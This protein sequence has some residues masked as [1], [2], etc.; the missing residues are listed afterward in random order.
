MFFSCVY[1]GTRIVAFYDERPLAAPTIRHS[2]CSILVPQY[3][4]RCPQCTDY[5]R[6]LHA[7]VSHLSAVEGEDRIAVSSHTNYR[8][9]STPKKNKRLKLLHATSRACHAKLERLKSKLAK[10]ID[11]KGVAVEPSMTTDLHQIMREE[12]ENAL[13]EPGSFQYVFWKQQKAA[14]ECKDIRGMCWHPAMIKFCLFLRHG[15]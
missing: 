11:E 12:E 8:Y 10:A 9:L 3:E 13:V 1:V 15:I 14:A 7:M 5:H 4:P 2:L 6:T